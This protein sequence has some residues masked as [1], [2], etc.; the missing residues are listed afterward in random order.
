MKRVCIV[1]AGASGITAAKTLHERG[2]PFDCYELGSGIG[3]VWRYQNDNG[4]SAAYRSLHINTSKQRMNY[5]D[6]PFP[7]DYPTFPHHSKILEYFENYVDHFGFREHIQ[8]NTCVEHIAPRKDDTT[9][10]MVY[11]V[12]LHTGDVHTYSHVMVANGHHWH[13][14]LPDP[15]FKGEFNGEEIH[16]TGYKEP[17][18]YMGKHV[19]VVG[20][21][22]SGVDI[23]VD[24]ARVAKNVYLSTR[25]G[26]YI[27]PK[28]MLG[29]PLDHWLTP[30]SA[31]LP[32]WMTSIAINALRFLT[33]GSQKQYGI[34]TPNSPLQAQHPTISSDLPHYVG[35]GKIQ[36]K[37]NIREK[38]GDSV[39][40]EDGSR[41]TVDSIIYATGYNIRF[42]F[43]DDDVI[44]PSEN[45]VSLYHL[46]VHPEYQSLY[47][48][49][50]CQP[51]G[52]VMPIS[53]RQ[54]VWVA[55][56]IEGYSALPSRSEMQGEIRER[57]T[58][59]HA[60]YD[61]RPRH[62]I[63]VDFFPYMNAL[64]EEIHAGRQRAQQKA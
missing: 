10:E 44:N 19:V 32:I 35:H 56:L 33:I 53:E 20:I 60:R 38:D 39:V 37:P 27:I 63:Q 17:E 43:L 24:I 42:P 51:L 26:A 22:N 59:I 57:K 30:A 50:L 21:G 36:M 40:F 18:P 61:K 11:D 2:I 29:R 1:G 34:P 12:R 13:P 54:S 4:R 6:F 7:D 8:F 25:S 62:T 46:T 3:G 64:Q 31:K 14:R 5:S 15:P 23:A 45:D 28:Y 47:F 58:R 9:G 16:S 52:A 41:E 49:G 55:D 48:I